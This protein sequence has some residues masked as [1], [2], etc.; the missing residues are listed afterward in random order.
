[1]FEDFCYQADQG[2]PPPLC[3][4]MNG[5][6]PLVPQRLFFCFNYQNKHLNVTLRCLF[7]VIIEGMNKET[8]QKAFWSLT[9]RETL[10]ELTTIKN[11]LS[12]KEAERRLKSFGENVFEKTKRI[13]KLHI[14]LG[15][16]KS[17]LI[18]ILIIAS[19]FTLFLQDWVDSAV[20]ILAIV[21]NTALGFYQ[22]NR[23]EEALKHLKSYI[24][25]R[26]RVIRDG[27]EHE[28]PASDVVPGDIVHLKNGVRISADARVI[29]AHTLFVDEAILTGES[30]PIT[31]QTEPLSKSTELADRINMVWAGTLVVGGSGFCVV[32]SSGSNT[33]IGRIAQLVA[34]TKRKKTPLQLSI[35]R[36]AWFITAGLTFIVGSIFALGIYRGENMSD[37]FLVSVAIAVSA[38]PEA[39][40]VALTV[41]LAVGVERLVKRKGVVRKLSAVESLGSTTV[42]LTDKTGT[43]TQAKMEM[44]DILTTEYL[45]NNITSQMNPKEGLRKEQVDILKLALIN[46]DILIENPN[47]NPKNWIIQGNPLELNIVK[48]SARYDIFIT[49]LKKSINYRKVLEFSSKY[50]F[51]AT[52]VE[53]S[54]EFEWDDLRGNDFIAVLGAPDILLDK[55]KVNKNDYI[56]I[57]DAIEKLSNDGMRI[58]GVA[59]QIVPDGKEI[60]ELKSQDVKNLEFAG[61]ISFYDPVRPEVV[62]AMNKVKD[63]GVHVVMVTGDLAGTAVSVA[64][65]LGWKIT[66]GNV[67]SG[68]DLKAMS[69]EELLKDLKNIRI[70]ARVSPQDKMRIAQ[71][72]KK[73]GEIVA[74]T[75]DGVNDAPGLKSVDIGI[76]MGSGTDVAKEVADLVLLD[77]NFQTIVAAI[78]EGRRVLSNIKKT[79]IYLL[80][81]ALDEVILIG[82]SLLLGLPLPLNALQILW[83]N[84]FS[85]SVPALAFAFEDNYE[86]NLQNTKGKKNRLID[87]QVLFMILALG[88]STSILLF[89]LYWYLLNAGY[90]EGIVK[91]FIFASFAIYTLFLAWP[92]RSLKKN[93]FQYNPFSNKWIVIGIGFGIILTAAALY[94]PFLQNVLGTQP[95][96]VPWLLLLLVWLIINITLVEITKWFFRRKQQS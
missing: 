88:I 77:D 30:L 61:I 84:F 82:G 43:L 44:R 72:F 73:T 14:F 12:Q 2:I 56:K 9:T 68:R 70:F 74:M 21:I 4:W 29:E 16:F 13:T 67:I 10:T 91:S 58:V 28:I 48:H 63:L 7:C 50:K 78:E 24:K 15:Q 76:A 90:Q 33:E 39:L 57:K 81:D 1:M 17:P 62:S 46:T 94:V 38:I 47:D 32:T 26:V 69:D 54:E 96:G 5:F 89:G 45:K 34:D 92:L 36:I 27:E 40:P 51:S 64:R 59:A 60:K 52:Y 87:G 20:I 41:T 35:G 71:L 6:I 95:L 86:S 25:E 19:A 65:I 22:E 80:S 66:D 3:W 18:F 23:A 49:T 31:K 53:R 11:G 83:V 79:I 93:I 85:D 8:T 75:G 55:S 42:I 37:M